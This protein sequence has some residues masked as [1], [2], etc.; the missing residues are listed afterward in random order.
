METIL[1]WM[2]A[3]LGIVVPVLFG[4]AI[5]KGITASSFDSDAILRVAFKNFLLK[6]R[7]LARL[8]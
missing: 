4:W 6:L 1:A 5:H 7:R 8:P 2:G 3:V